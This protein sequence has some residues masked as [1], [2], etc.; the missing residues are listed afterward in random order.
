[1]RC[2]DVDPLRAIRA[3]KRKKE[4][5]EAILAEV[6][7]FGSYLFAVWVRVAIREC[8]SCVLRVSASFAAHTCEMS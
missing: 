6:S 3:K 7:E 1:M 8:G 5:K 2:I 4:E